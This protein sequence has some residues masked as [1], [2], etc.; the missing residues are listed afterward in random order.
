[1]SLK[2]F[3][4]NKAVFLSINQAIEIWITIALSIFLLGF[5]FF[6]SSSKH[7]TFF[8]ISVCAPIILLFPFYCKKLKLQNALIITTL[9]F[10]FYLCLNSLWSI[11]Y[12]SYQSIKYFRYLITLFCLFAAVYLV[13]YRKPDYSTLFFPAIVSIGFFHYLYGIYIHFQNIP[14][15]LIVR[16]DDPIDSAMLA[17]LL[18]LTCIWL[19]IENKSWKHSLFYLF[20]SIPFIT[21]M[22]ISKSRGPQL[23]LLTTFPLFAYYQNQHIK[24]LFVSTVILLTSLTAILIFTDILQTIFSRGVSTPYR[25][26]IWMTSLNESLDYFW[27]GQGASHKPP[28]HTPIGQFNHSHNI[29]LSIF[30]MGGIIAVLLF[31]TQ[32]S[33][34]FISGQKNKSSTHRLWIVWLFF[35]LFC[36]MTNGRYPLSRP[37]SAWLA[38]WIPIAFICASYSHFLS[39][40]N[41]K[42][43]REP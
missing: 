7:N 28:L 42:N 6:P 29:L 35:G 32:L 10:L 24:K 1:M 19:A 22:L 30:R 38:Y 5:F 18:L 2:D 36:L 20:L 11:H 43:I 16:Y 12:T 25:I 3:T 41:E 8:Y 17:G 23:A 37:N 14:H 40:N 4:L 15:P 34:S 26:D 27:F 21:V 13:H 31:S 39:K 33:L 9:A